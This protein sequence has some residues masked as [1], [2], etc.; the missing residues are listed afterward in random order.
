MTGPEDGKALADCLYRHPLKHTL[1]TP[2]RATWRHL[3]KVA[4]SH[5]RA[6]SSL[7]RGA[8]TAPPGRHLRAPSRAVPHGPIGLPLAGHTAR[9]M[10][11]I[12]GWT[13]GAI[14]ASPPVQTSSL[15]CGWSS[16]G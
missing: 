1:K 8:A 9:G 6:S 4:R 7:Q 12:M 11:F 3:L 15:S 5:R 14:A 13:E 10:A 2:R 16:L